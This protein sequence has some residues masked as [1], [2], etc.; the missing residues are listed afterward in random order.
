[1][2][3]AAHRVGVNLGFGDVDSLAEVE[4]GMVGVSD[5]MSISVN[6]R[7]RSRDITWPPYG[8]GGLLEEAVLHEQHPH[9]AGQVPGGRGDQCFPTSQKN[10]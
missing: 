8:G 1:M 10:L 5:T 7:L 6:M 3:D 9:G 2:G 4:E